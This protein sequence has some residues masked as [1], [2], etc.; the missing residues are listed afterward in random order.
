MRV[1]TTI[2]SD[3]QSFLTYEGTVSTS[4]QASEAVLLQRSRLLFP[5]T[6]QA[7]VGPFIVDALELELAE[8]GYVLSTRLRARLETLPAE[9]AADFKRWACDAIASSLGANRKHQPLFRHFPHAIPEDTHELWIRRVLTY[10]FQRRDQECVH[11]RRVGTTHVLN[12][13]EH[14]VCDHCYDGENYSACPICNRQV[15]QSSPFFKPSV[16]RGLPAENVRFKVLDLGEDVQEASRDLFLSF[17]VRS[18]AMPPDDR[19]HLQVLV[20]DWSNELLDWLPETISVKENV[21]IVVGTLFQIYSPGTVL[22]V[23]R[24]YLKTATDVLRVLAAYSDADPGL[25]GETIIRDMVVEER[26]RWSGPIAK[27]L[28]QPVSR[29]YHRAQVPLKVRRFKLARVGRPL[30]RALFSLLESFDGDTLIEDML[31]YRPYWVWVGAKS[32]SIWRGNPRLNGMVLIRGCEMRF[33]RREGAGR[34][35]P[36]GTTTRG[37]TKGE[38]WRE[39]HRDDRGARRGTRRRR[40]NSAA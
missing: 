39:R 36:D 32:H 24:S 20:K 26:S 1:G 21:A 12:P 18:Q 14:I 34:R 40:R 9:G 30:R 31:R 15:D 3:P 28:G 7:R 5:P 22:E 38:A 10:F 19:A 2:G 27:L 16:E 6:G 37:I 4:R 25:Q 29:S 8:F 17:C 13:C 23:A 35:V 33:A 11:C